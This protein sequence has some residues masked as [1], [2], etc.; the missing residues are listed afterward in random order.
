MGYGSAFHKE[1]V[2]TSVKFKGPPPTRTI[3]DDE[4]H[5]HNGIGVYTE[6]VV[7]S[8]ADSIGFSE[9]SGHPFIREKT[10]SLT[11]TV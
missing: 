4:S 8:D 2:V 10:T 11:M 6:T 5:A 1:S 7:K 9:S 3:D